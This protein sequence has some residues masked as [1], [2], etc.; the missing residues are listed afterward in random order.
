MTLVTALNSGWYLHW[1]AGAPKKL[2]ICYAQLLPTTVL[3]MATRYNTDTTFQIT[4]EI[5][6]CSSSAGNL[7]AYT[8][9]AATSVEAVSCSEGN[10]GWRWVRPCAR[11]PLMKETLLECNVRRSSSAGI[12]CSIMWTM[13]RFPK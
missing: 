5:P 12:N 1:D 4:A 11:P 8:F 3:V 10:E 6:W 9:S 13:L 2:V 7:C